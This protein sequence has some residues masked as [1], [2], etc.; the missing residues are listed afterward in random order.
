MKGQRQSKRRWRW[1]AGAIVLLLLVLVADYFLYPLW[2]RPGG[3]SF[4]RGENASWLHFS[5][6]FGEHDDDEIHTLTQQ[7]R[8]QQVRDAY[9][10]VRFIQKNGTLHFRYQEKAKR[11]VSILHRAAPE[12]R[13]VAWIYIGNERGLTGVDIANREVRRKI[14]REALWLVSTCGFDGVQLDYEICES[15]NQELLSLLRETRAALPPRK[16]LSVATAMWLPRPFQA[17]GWSEEYFAQI[18]ATCDQIVVMA[19]DSALYFPRHYVWLMR[20]QA[21][22]VTRATMRGNPNC[23]VLLGVPTYEDGGPSHHPH[24]ENLYLALK[25]VREGLADS[26]SAP[27][28]FAGVAIFADYTTDNGEWHTYRKWWLQKEQP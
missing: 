5:W 26:Q 8:S 28:A 25:G 2:S 17:W 23:R 7:L 21:I 6:Y 3:R 14:V 13:A 11:L 22:H 24:A 1:L 20:Q 27:D 9:F 15:G 18:A 19:Y 16:I 10:H 4:N 12:I